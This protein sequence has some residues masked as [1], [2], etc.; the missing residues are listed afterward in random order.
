[1]PTPFAALEARL[2][3]TAFAHL[4]NATADF[5]SGVVVDGIFAAPY[6]EAFGM[7]GGSKPTFTAQTSILPATLEGVA[8]TIKAVPYTVAE[9]HPDG[10]DVSVLY[11][12]TV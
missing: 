10:V 8:V 2:T 6:M 11:L 9:V 3:A 12:E 4:A 1:M 5:G 7:V